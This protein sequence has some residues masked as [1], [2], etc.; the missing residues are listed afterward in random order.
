MNERTERRRNAVARLR[1]LGDYNDAAEWAAE[2]GVSRDATA[3]LMQAVASIN[4][5][6]SGDHP[7]RQTPKAAG[8]RA[9]QLRAAR[10]AIGLLV[11][12]R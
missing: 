1:D 7:R 6:L 12:V 9:V 3:M 8:L 2:Y 4:W 10:D 11:V 5:E